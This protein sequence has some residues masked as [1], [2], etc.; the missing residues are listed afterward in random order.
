M[1]LTLEL[2]SARKEADAALVLWPLNFKTST[3]AVAKSDLHQRYYPCWQVY[4]VLHDLGV[5]VWS[6]FEIGLSF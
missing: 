5:V 6:H 3:P 2:L 1:S 4:V